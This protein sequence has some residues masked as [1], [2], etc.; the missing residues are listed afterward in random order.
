MGGWEIYIIWQR[1]NFKRNIPEL[2]A[3][4]LLLPG[5]F[6]SDFSSY[7][8]FV[9]NGL[10]IINLIL[11]VVALR[12]M[13]VSTSTLNQIIRVGIFSLLPVFWFV[14]FNSSNPFHIEYTLKATSALSSGFNPNQVTTLLGALAVLLIWP[15]W[16]ENKLHIIN[17]V[18]F[19]II[20]WWSFLALSRGW[21][22]SLII[23]IV[24]IPGVLRI[25]SKHSSWCSGHQIQWFGKVSLLL[26]TSFFASNFVSDWKV[27]QLFFTVPE[28][29]KKSVSQMDSYSSGRIS[30]I[31]SDWGIFQNHVLF[32]M[33]VGNSTKH[34]IKEGEKTDVASHT[35]FSRLLAEHG[36]G[37]FIV[38]LCLLFVPVFLIVTCN[39]NPI[40]QAWYIVCFGLALG[41][42]AHSAMRTTITPYFF[43]LGFI[44]I[45]TSIIAFDS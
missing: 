4:I 31:K 11:G 9:F 29:S 23:I 17:Y 27:N 42:A 40:Q 22:F 2:C 10:G 12:G 15:F 38:V 32:G 21:F 35:E 1:G 7:N 8:P 20:C 19:G 6:L 36:I 13:H 18:L 43:A 37:G 25:S 16:K 3:F 41:S 28:N 44:Q 30:L 45:D 39:N 14:L 26:I 33:G 5:V 34:R 24:G